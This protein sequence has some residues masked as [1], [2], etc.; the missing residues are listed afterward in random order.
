MTNT[1]RVFFCFLCV[2]LLVWSTHLNDDIIE[3][4]QQNG[5]KQG[6]L[7]D[8]IIETGDKQG[9]LNDEIIE[10][11]DKQVHLNDE[12][13][14]TGDK[15]V[16]LNDDIIETLQQNGD[17]Q[18]Y[19]NDDI[20]ETLQQNGDN[21]GHLND[22]IIETPQQ[23]GDK[24]VHL[25]DDII[26]TGDKQVHL[27]DDIIET[28]QQNGDKQ[29]HLNDDIIETPQ[30]NGD[31]E[32]PG[33]VSSTNSMVIVVSLVLC[34]LGILY[35]TIKEQNLFTQTIKRKENLQNGQTSKGKGKIVQPSKEKKV[36]DTQSFYKYIY[37]NW[38]ES[39]LPCILSLWQSFKSKYLN[40]EKFPLDGSNL[41]HPCILFNFIPINSRL[42]HEKWP[43]ESKHWSNLAGGNSVVV[44]VHND[45]LDS[46]NDD[47]FDACLSS[48]T[49]Q[50][51]HQ[52]LKV[53]FHLEYDISGFRDPEQT[54]ID[55]EKI[56][57]EMEKII[58]LV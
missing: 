40:V 15:Q 47:L 33:I 13:I 54:L 56:K 31:K 50:G 17:K 46:F 43:R 1:L 34:L 27:N 44:R 39:D 4:L 18:R 49:C 55:V 41:K 5:D 53:K 11:G 57:Q 48:S 42:D 16:H 29:G 19:L 21:Q 45:A 12:I 24:Q 10:T 35:T 28:P 3:T 37:L 30:Q 8:D 36:Q 22:N 38:N 9:H 26:E 23:N 7:N 58:E 52:V 25:N 20:I 32:G 51:G 14:E 6:H 2:L